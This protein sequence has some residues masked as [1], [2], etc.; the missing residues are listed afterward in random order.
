MFVLLCARDLPKRARTHLHTSLTRTLKHRTPLSHS[1]TSRTYKR[2]HGSVTAA[3]VTAAATAAA[4]F[5]AAAATAAAAA[6][7]YALTAAARAVAT[8]Q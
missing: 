1:Y 6:A 5:T 4:S 7:F 3:D 2:H 8:A